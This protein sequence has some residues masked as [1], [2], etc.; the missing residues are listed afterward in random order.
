MGQ[1]TMLKEAARCRP[2]A[3]PIGEEAQRA[4]LQKMVN[5]SEAVRDE[6]DYLTLRAR[7]EVSAALQASHPI[8]RVAHLTLAQLY[9]KRSRCVA[10]VR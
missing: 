5:S 6:R 1:R 9:E 8:A 10:P 3:K 2:L 7:Q 4:L